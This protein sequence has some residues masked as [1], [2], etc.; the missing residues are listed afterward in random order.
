M[1]HS[2]VLCAFS[3]V[4]AIQSKSCNMLSFMSIKIS[5]VNCSLTG[6]KVCCIKASKLILWFF[7]FCYFYFVFWLKG[8]CFPPPLGHHVSP[9][10]P[11][12]LL[13]RGW[14]ESTFANSI[15]HCLVMW[16][17]HYGCGQ[18]EGALALLWI[19]LWLH[20]HSYLSP[21]LFLFPVFILLSLPLC[22]V[23]EKDFTTKLTL[24]N[25]YY[26]HWN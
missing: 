24:I 8:S 22:A 9:L 10:S 12:T 26:W 1:G 18:T 4:A 2:Y 5:Y 13:L 6:F 14:G 19:W 21:S 16:I 25:L 3:V 20:L 11:S 17:H 15:T 7:F 23:M